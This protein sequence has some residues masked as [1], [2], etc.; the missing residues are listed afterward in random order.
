MTKKVDFKEKILSFWGRKQGKIITAKI[1][2]D[3]YNLIDEKAITIE[4]K[5]IIK[6]KEDI[7]YIY[8]IFHDVSDYI[9]NILQITTE[10]DIQQL[11]KNMRLLA[12]TFYDYFVSNNEDG[13]IVYAGEKLLEIIRIVQKEYPTSQDLLAYRTE[14]MNILKNKIGNICD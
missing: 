7:D 5:I 12:I 8:D 3:F 11:F 9:P 1:F 4:E 6:K 2:Q 10:E 13:E 14:I